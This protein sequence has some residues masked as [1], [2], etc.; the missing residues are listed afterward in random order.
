MRTAVLAL[1]M[2]AGAAALGADEHIVTNLI[3]DLEL[4]VRVDGEEI[5]TSPIVSSSVGIIAF[6]TGEDWSVVEIYPA[7]CPRPAIVCSEMAR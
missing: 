1:I 7:S 6:E 4:V 3:P 2:L 5:P